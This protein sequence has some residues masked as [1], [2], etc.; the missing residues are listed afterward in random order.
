MTPRQASDKAGSLRNSQVETIRKK[1]VLL[2]LLHPTN[3]NLVGVDVP[4]AAVTVAR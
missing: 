2:E 4:L 1:T 3:G